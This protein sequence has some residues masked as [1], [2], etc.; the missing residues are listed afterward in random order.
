MVGRLGS[1]RC[2]HVHAVEDKARTA[3]GTRAFVAVQFFSN[4]RLAMWKFTKRAWWFNQKVIPWRCRF[5]QKS[6]FLFGKASVWWF[7]IWKM[8]TLFYS[9]N[10]T[11]S[12]PWCVVAAW[13]ALAPANSLSTS[14]QFIHIS[15]DSYIY[16]YEFIYDYNTSCTVA[17][18]ISFDIT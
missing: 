11:C 4:G 3:R 7:N 1:F 9:W 5:Q 18:F 10:L 6:K 14:I 16:I 8:W 12:Q 13:S 15:Y 2:L 17:T